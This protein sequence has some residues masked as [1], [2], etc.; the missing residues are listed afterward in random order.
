MSKSKTKVPIRMIPISRINILNP[1][2][3]NHRIFHA[4]TDNIAQVGLKRPITVKRDSASA[5]KDY[6]LVCGQGR[7]EAFLA[8]GQKQIPAIVIDASEE[9]AL[10]MSLVENLARRQYRTPDILQGIE[11][12]QKQGYSTGEIARKTGLTYEYVSQLLTLIERGEERLL[13]AVETGKIPISV[14]AVIADTPNEEIQHALQEAYENNLL[15]G[16]KLRLAK[17][18]VEM[19]Y[20]HGKTTNNGKVGAPQTGRK[21]TTAQGIWK[22]YQ[23]EADRQR[24]MVADGNWVREKLAFITQTLRDL[25]SDRAFN[26]MLRAEGLHTLPKQMAELINTEKSA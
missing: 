16:H 7:L 13:T 3:R 2:M 12:L 8:C 14:A 23:K 17:R 6:D 24:M 25:Y 19:R 11:I 1:R 22:N 26:D 21:C 10:V 18:L 4:I 9:D 15:R 5:D 20:R